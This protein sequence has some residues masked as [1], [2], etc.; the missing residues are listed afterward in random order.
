[1]TLYSVLKADILMENFSLYFKM[2]IF[3]H[4]LLS[5]KIVETSTL[6]DT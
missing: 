2:H 6:L 3:L 5:A 1:M 4:I